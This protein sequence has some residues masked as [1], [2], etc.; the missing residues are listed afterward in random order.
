MGCV[1]HGLIPRRR[2]R[3][4]A[5]SA[6]VLG[7]LVGCSSDGAPG[8]AAA[9]PPKSPPSASTATECAKLGGTWRRAGMLQTE[10]CDLPTKDGGKA[11]TD[12]AQCENLCVIA[13]GQPPGAS[14]SGTC[15]ASYRTVGTCLTHIKAGQV[16]ADC[17]D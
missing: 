8:A 7:L 12:D 16:V 3:L 4:A 5:S 17:T 14:P 1:V 13:Q 9:A 11:C 15:H 10:V 6:L 2:W